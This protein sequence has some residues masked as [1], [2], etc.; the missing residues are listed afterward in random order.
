MVAF[1]VGLNFESR[2]SID[3]QF[4]A[5]ARIKTFQSGKLGNGAVFD[6]PLRSRKRKSRCGPSSRTHRGHYAFTEPVWWH[7]EAERETG[8]GLLGK[9]VDDDAGVWR[10]RSK[11]RLIVEKAVDVVLDDRKVELFDNA[12]EIGP[13]R[14]VHRHPQWILNHRLNVDGREMGLA[15]R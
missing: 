13:A 2:K 6:H 7:D 8:R 5:S 9:T 4:L 11:R 10:E 14:R 1:F 12:Q 15:V 3:R